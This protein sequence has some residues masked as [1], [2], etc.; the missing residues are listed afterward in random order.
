[1]NKGPLSIKCINELGKILKLHGSITSQGGISPIRYLD[2][3]D[4]NPNSKTVRRRLGYAFNLL[5]KLPSQ[6]LRKVPVTLN[7]YSK[8]TGKKVAGFR[9]SLRAVN[10]FNG[11]PLN[12]GYQDS[13]S[14]LRNQF[15]KEFR[16]ISKIDQP[17][18]LLSKIFAHFLNRFLEGLE[19]AEA[20]SLSDYCFAYRKNK[21]HHNLLSS[22]EEW[23]FEEGHYYAVRT[24]I[25]SFFDCIQFTRMRTILTEA[26]QSK[27]IEDPFFVEWCMTLAFPRKI[28]SWEV[29]RQSKHRIP[30][31]PCIRL[32]KSVGVPQGSPLSAP[33]SNLYLSQVD[34]DMERIGKEKGFRY[35]RYADDIMIL[36]K[37]TEMMQSA[38]TLLKDSLSDHMLDLTLNLN[39]TECEDIRSGKVS[40][41]GFRWTGNSIPGQRKSMVDAKYFNFRRKITEA[42]TMRMRRSYLKKKVGTLSEE[43]YLLKRIV[44]TINKKLLGKSDSKSK[45]GKTYPMASHYNHGNEQLI[46]QQMQRLDRWIHYRVARFV[47]GNQEKKYGNGRRCSSTKYVFKKLIPAYNKKVLSGEYSEEQKLHL[48]HLPR[49]FMDRHRAGMVTM[50]GLGE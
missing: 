20:P 7:L 30:F 48:H 5:G 10:L 45:S 40:F 23:I 28:A 14:E 47:V 15:N 21:S 1:M 25:K 27:G 49:L 33:L 16:F 38:L 9:Q 34:F 24:D 39:K 50:Y 26:L 18:K 43:E 6:K 35:L 12:P 44:T 19:I 37:S 4:V 8:K 22:A 32:C 2:K 36:C 13:F 11:R 3:A 42:T 41:M 17:A 46:L 29:K 31:S